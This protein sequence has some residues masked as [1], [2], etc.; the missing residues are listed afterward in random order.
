MSENSERVKKHRAERRDAILEYMGGECLR[1]G[2]SEWP[3]LHA[4]HVEPSE[5]DFALFDGRTRSLE[6]ILDEIQKCI[7]LC[8]NCHALVH[9]FN[10]TKFLN[11]DILPKYIST[12]RMT[13]KEKLIQVCIECSTVIKAKSTR[14][15]KCENKRRKP[16]IQWPLIEDLISEVERTSYSAVGRRLAVS[17]NAVKKHITNHRPA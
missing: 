17:G 9:T 3:A 10:E 6:S 5:K 15:Q 1:C 14:C 7:L 13:L 12:D 11:K 2:F 16:K 8:A 4:H